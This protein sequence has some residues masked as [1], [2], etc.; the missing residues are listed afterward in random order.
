M[1]HI[2]KFLYLL[3]CLVPVSCT[4]ESSRYRDTSLLE[5][6]PTLV[7]NKSPNG[8]Y[9]ST[10]DSAI[11][12]KQEPGLGD[13]V[14]LTESTPPQ[15][16]IRQSY[17]KA[18]STINQALKLNAIK[19]TDHERDKGHLYVSYGSPGLF[20]LA[21]SFLKDDR[22]DPTYLLSLKEDGAETTV[23][24]TMANPAD[25][26]S[27]SAISDGSVDK[28]EDNSEDLLQTLY[29]TIRDDSVDE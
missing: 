17:D 9:E 8:Q 10:D 26:S 2:V 15:L 18:W 5:R 14:T 19:I 29:K 21:T 12:K 27:S 4:T 20:D 11:P 13:A 7:I 25:Q 23:T 16:K 1:Q 24:A 22:K 28:P 3:I 6:P